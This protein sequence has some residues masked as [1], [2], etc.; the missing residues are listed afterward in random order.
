M[1]ENILIFRTDRI[2]DLILT[3]PAIFTIKKY[4][5]NSNLTL[6]TSK[7]NYIYA[8]N[9]N[10]FKRPLFS[11]LRGSLSKK[12]SE[13]IRDLL[14]SDAV[15]EQYRGQPPYI[16]GITLYML[17]ISTTKKQKTLYMLDVIII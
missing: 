1:F 3:C 12:N 9:L 5:A 6:V 13:R 10:I 7:K 11:S 4:F 15:L 16:T 8:I 2:G 14:A 17:E